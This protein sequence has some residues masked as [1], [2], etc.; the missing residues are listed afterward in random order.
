MRAA[1]ASRAEGY[2][3]RVMD[4]SDLPASSGEQGDQPDTRGF[5]TWS[6]ETRAGAARADGLELRTATE[7]GQSF[8]YQHQTTSH[9]AFQVE[10][11]WRQ[12][13]D[14]PEFAVGSVSAAG[15]RHSGRLTVRNYGF[16][17]T[18]RTFLDAAVG[19]IYSDVTQVLGRTSRL[20]VG[21]SVVRG[22]SARMVGEGFELR[23]GTGVRGTLAGSPYPGFESTRGSLTWAGASV[24][25]SDGVAVGVQVNQAE[26]I[27]A[28]NSVFPLSGL[29]EDVSSVAAGLAWTGSG[30]DAP[31]RARL[32][33]LRSR[34]SRSAPG[35]QREAQ[36]WIGE[37]NFSTG[38]Y[39]H[40]LGAYQA[41]ANLRFGDYTL[42]TSDARGG[43]WR[44]NTSGARYSWA[45]GADY[46]FLDSEP[47]FGSAAS[48][49]I[50]LSGG[51]QYRLDRWDAVGGYASLGFTRYSGGTAAG[52][53]DG[54]HR[55]ISANAYYQTR[56]RGWAPTR[57][58]VSYFGN[59]RLVANDIPATGEELAWEQEWLQGADDDLQRP[60]FTTT[61]AVARD[62]SGGRTEIQPAAGA[63][64]RLWPQ[65]DWLLSGTLRYT[66]RDSNLYTS[67]GLSGT[68][69]TEKQL[70]EGWRVGAALSLNQA[71]VRLPLAGTAEPE[72][73]RSNDRSISVYVRWEGAAGS[74]PQGVGVREAGTAGAGSV[75]GIVFLDA[76]H[77][78]RQSLNEV[79]ASGVEVILDGRFRVVTDRFGRF[80][81]PLVATGRHQLSL[82]PETVPLPWGVPRSQDVRV[83]VPLRGQAFVRIPV[84]RTGD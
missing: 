77:D 69:T 60:E 26:D 41:D 56:I 73:I 43:Y 42:G 38:D 63:T 72:V 31:P 65:A 76:D 70:A 46:D 47:V 15:R 28:L 9:G 45:A 50:G 19:D 21:S 20:S 7:L 74:T 18:P 75:G 68:V 2:V 16:P 23:A 14:A 36:G 4:P 8:R 5:R 61:L 58:R 10:A 12:G 44:V 67:R 11:D 79:G 27:A 84:V 22:A 83:E 71:I 49:R 29:D 64:F 52:W 66:A 34:A 62:R 53:L 35:L 1:G 82:T 54:S 3:D 30:S 6:V 57:L 13:P 51:G 32:V 78:G 37:G 17:L 25:V 39:G 48:R 24:D 55:S 59:E 33:H 81:F 80:D 40:E